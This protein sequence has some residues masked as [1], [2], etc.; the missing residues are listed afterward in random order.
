MA[1]TL[2]MTDERAGDEVALT[3]PAAHPTR[4]ALLGAGLGA[5]VAAIAG[6]LGRPGPATAADGSQIVAGFG[7]TATETT[8]ITNN[9]N[10]RPVFVGQSQAGTGLA[11]NSRS[12]NGVRGF[13]SEN[14]AI[15][16][17]TEA[18]NNAS[19][20]LGETTSERGYG[21]FGA[22]HA[23][24][25]FASLAG[26]KT[27][28]AVQVPNALGFV[29]VQASAGEAATALSVIGKAKFSRSGRALVP[30][31]RSFVLVDVQGELT[32]GSL[33]LATPMLNRTGVYVQ[34]AV[35]N[36]N[37]GQIRI[38]LNKVAST[39]SSTPI[40]WMVLS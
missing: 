35:P 22:N 24:E 1:T 10:D 33:V 26:P 29:G 4:R 28:L 6:A 13:S 30:A 11:G 36:P 27:G 14:T 8:S 21:V 2:E 12:G 39:A 23:V 3:V 40:A 15:V 18:Q 20:V 34:S 32:S 31:G 37:T 9:A 7:T 5:L 19:G 16:G 38:N 25:T 17:S